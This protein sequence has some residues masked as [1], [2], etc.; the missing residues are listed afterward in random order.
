MNAMR[1]VA[2]NEICLLDQSGGQKKGAEMRKA[3]EED[4]KQREAH[5]E[6]DLD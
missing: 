4:G 1:S 2:L 6:G 5:E 3:G